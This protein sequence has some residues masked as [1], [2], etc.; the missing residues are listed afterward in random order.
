MKTVLHNF[1]KNT[2]LLYTFIY[3]PVFRQFKSDFSRL[4]LCFVSLSLS[5]T[6]YFI[7]IELL[8]TW[9]LL[10]DAQKQFCSL[11]KCP[12]HLNSAFLWFASRLICSIH[13]L[14]HYLIS[15]ESWYSYM[16]SLIG[17]DEKSL[18]YFFSVHS[19]CYT[20]IHWL[21]ISWR[22][23]FWLKH[24]IFGLCFNLFVENGANDC[25]LKASLSVSRRLPNSLNSF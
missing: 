14:F 19:S 15:L 13:I 10:C 22:Y 4:N 25:R 6:L 5:L 23:A 9:C 18:L 2:K 12:N 16:Q 17:Y 21:H 8:V 7:E 3:C 20:K 24:L 1:T 11:I